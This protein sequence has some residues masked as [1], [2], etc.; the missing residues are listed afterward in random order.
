MRFDAQF[1]KPGY[2]EAEEL[3]KIG[4]NIKTVGEVITS[5]T[6]GVDLR[7]FVPEGIPY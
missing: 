4:S 3:L 1:Y 6:N 7:E 5:I 2:L